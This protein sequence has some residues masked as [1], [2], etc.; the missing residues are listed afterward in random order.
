M[1][2][3]LIAPK[4]ASHQK[5]KSWKAQSFLEVAIF[6]PILLMMVSGLAEFGF[7]MNEYLNLIDGPREGARAA[8]DWS[9]LDD[10][11]GLN[12]S[13]GSNSIPDVL[14][15][16]PVY[17]VNAIRPIT[18]NPDEDDIV[19]SIYGIAC[20]GATCTATKQHE[21]SWATH[22]GYPGKTS[23]FT[24]S[25]LA[26]M[27]NAGPGTKPNSGLVL[28]E[29]YYSY[30]QKLALPWIQIFGYL[31]ILPNPIQL[32]TYTIMPMTAAEPD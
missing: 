32:S 18:L 8:V 11:K 7:L 31:G 27:I 30:H 29:L 25:D 9:L 13:G 12:C 21:Y 22:N 5:A 19:V 24:A 1:R 15:C 16:T 28:V 20:S 26:A 17:A 14:D 4:T 2:R 3:R 10:A 23:R 6:L